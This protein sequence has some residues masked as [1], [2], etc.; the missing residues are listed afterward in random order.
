MNATESQPSDDSLSTLSFTGAFV[1]GL[2]VV[3][4]FY[5]LI[6]A[7]IVTKADETLLGMETGLASQSITIE[8][9]FVFPELQPVAEVHDAPVYARG[10]T[11]PPEQAVHTVEQAPVEQPTETAQVTAPPQETHVEDEIPQGREPLSPAPIKG[12]TKDSQF[13]KLPIISEKGV[14]P[15]MAYKKPFSIPKGPIIAIAVAGYGLSAQASAEVLASVPAEVSLILSPYAEDA[16]KWQKQAR[17]TGHEIWMQVPIQA[18]NYPVDDPGPKALLTR[19]G[20][21]Q[22]QNILDWVLA[23]TTGYAGFA[24]TTD[25]A[26]AGSAQQLDS[27][28]KSAF[29]RGLAFFEMNPAADPMIET[30]ALTSHYPYARSS[31]YLDETSLKALEAEARN[32]GYVVGILRPN[33]KSISA[34]NK[35]LATLPSKNITLVPVSLI[36]GTTGT[37]APVHA[38]PH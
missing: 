13:G 16:D 19:Y 11:P 29:G 23:R 15:F 24:A 9:A 26:F 27:L 38:Q 31:F 37:E 32:K 4:L 22:N 1:R 17:E 35:W 10:E 14:T 2:V 25:D 34:L 7:F 18:K 20:L 5:G 30:M 12:L 33:P 3:G 21:Q 28:L 8:R 36:A 6:V